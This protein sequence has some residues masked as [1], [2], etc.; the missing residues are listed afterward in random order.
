MSNRNLDADREVIPRWRSY[1]K[2]AMLGEMDTTNVTVK[3]N[4]VI[5]GSVLENKLFDWKTNKT[6][7]LAIDIINTAYTMDELEIV[8]QVGN[9][10][11]EKGVRFSSSM[12]DIITSMSDSNDYIYP[13]DDNIN[14]NRESIRELKKVLNSNPNNPIAWIES[15]RIYSILGEIDRAKKCMSNSLSLSKNNR[16][17]IRSAS[18]FYYQLG[19]Y[20]KALYL[21]RNAD[22]CKDDPWILATEIAMLSSDKRTSRNVK[23]GKRM[24]ESNNYS[25]YQVT[26]LAS[27]IATLEMNCGAHKKAKKI[28]GKSLLNPNENTLAQVM[29]ANEK[30]TS[31]TEIVLK[32]YRKVPLCYEALTTSKRLEND[33]KKALQYSKLWISDQP[34]SAEAYIEASYI[35]AVGLEKYSESMEHA[36]SGLKLFPND[37]TLN[38]NYI[39]A[40]AKCNDGSDINELFS[41]LEGLDYGNNFTTYNATRGLLSYKK[42]DINEA[43]ILY[44]SAIIRA[45]KDKKNINKAM[46]MLNQAQEEVYVGDDLSEEII[47]TTIKFVSSDDL[48]KI[49]DIKM[50]LEKLKK[51]LIDNKH[52]LSNGV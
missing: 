20:S 29:W 27:A 11:I 25:D 28:F 8:K 13:K 48:I 35:S 23:L 32:E 14:V 41:K 24:I 19:D 9:Y 43:R 17:I 21:L 15:S 7:G 16:Y 37:F 36:L 30:R 45:Q 52:N 47:K 34:F 38:N 4:E 46:A 6:I 40:K 22:S 10:L 33:W 42:G 51:T 44:N 3:Q 31:I 2:T 39:F 18:N 12:N 1:K 50:E 5:D 26:E 49:G